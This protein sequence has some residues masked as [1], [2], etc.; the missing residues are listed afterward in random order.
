RI[1]ATK[2]AGCAAGI[3]GA[4][5]GHWRG[6]R[7]T[8]TPRDDAATQRRARRGAPAVESSATRSTSSGTELPLHRESTSGI[9]SGNESDGGTS[10]RSFARRRDCAGKRRGVV[11]GTVLVLRGSTSGQVYP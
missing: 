9:G 6:K 2:R 8:A 7:H 1:A 3:P 5:N 10:Y 4:S 11:A